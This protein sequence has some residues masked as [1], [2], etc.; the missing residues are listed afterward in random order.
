MAQIAAATVTVLSIIGVAWLFIE[1]TRFFMLV[2]A[3]LVL[4]VIFDALA[5]RVTALIR[6]PRG[7]A[8]G[9][10]IVA[11]VSL[12]VGA[13][14]LFGTQLAREFDTIAE[15]IPPALAQIDASLS[16][17]GM[18]NSARE[19][20]GRGSS[21]VSK[22]LSQAGGYILAASS[23]FAD[24]V[25]V[26]VGAIFIA[27]NP[28]VYRRGLLLLMPQRAERTAEKSLDDMSRGLRGW[29]VGQAASSALVAI[30][31]WAGLAV[32]G[33]PAAG[34]L[35]LIAGLLDVIPMIGPIIA[36]VPA[37][38]LAFT[39]SPITA[40]WTAGLFLLIQQLQGNLLQPMIQKQAVNVPPAVLL[41]AVVA[42]GTLFGFLGVL[43]AAPLTVVIFVMVQRIYVKSLLGKDV[44][45]VGDD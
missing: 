38:L 21:N 42:S 5:R 15:S 34:G 8:L 32:L 14:T 27:G 35:G 2:F 13:F 36:A 25:L 45:I 7:A 43:L 10:S 4:A 30:L 23:G 3:A 37:I 11:L 39:V 9:L 12:F 20:F 44:Q 19:L 18:N 29:M 28:G 6:M 17:F 1:L 24:F 22:L 41:F 26:F 33:V 31:T 40:L 16:R